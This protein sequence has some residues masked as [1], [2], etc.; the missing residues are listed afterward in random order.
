MV[1]IGITYTTAFIIMSFA[2]VL[3][4]VFNL[5]YDTK[6]K[7]A[8][9]F[10]AAL[11]EL[12]F[13]FYGL[14]I[15]VSRSGWVEKRS[16]TSWWHDLWSAVG[17]HVPGWNAFWGFIGDYQP[18][19]WDAVILP[20][21]WLTLAI[22]VYGA[23]S[24]D[25]KAVVKGTRLESA[26][27]R[28]EASLAVRTHMVTR[29]LGAKFLGHWAH[30]LAIANTLRLTV[31]GGAP[32]FGLF[33]L[34]FV[35]I[36]VGEGYAWRG[37]LYLVGNDH[38]YLM[39]NVLFVPLNIVVDFGVAILT[40]CLLAATFDL[41]ATRDRARRAAAVS[42]RSGSPTPSPISPQATAPATP[43]PLAPSAQPR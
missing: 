18:F 12:V 24:E 2:F 21:A 26:A 34:C 37:L 20:A 10:G 41:A 43:G 4:D 1:L 6:D 9:A 7:R 32:L 23:Y 30:W 15:V 35:G 8:A 28:A 22:L 42:D 14:Q 31:R 11:C 40:T 5:W 38:P 19:F 39:W 17:E 36:K 33:A 25:A 13:F 16:A 27:R 29:Q 3:R